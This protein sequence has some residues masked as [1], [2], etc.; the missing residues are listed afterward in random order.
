MPKQLERD[1]Q[2]VGG[3]RLVPTVVTTAATGKGRAD[4]EVN[5]WNPG[6][7]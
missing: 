7:D 3:S 2:M 1:I 6:V 4:R 5:F